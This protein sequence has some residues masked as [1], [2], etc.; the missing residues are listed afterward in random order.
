M[1]PPQVLVVPRQP[2]KVKLAVTPVSLLAVYVYLR[3]RLDDRHKLVHELVKAVQEL[4][5]FLP[6]GQTVQQRQHSPEDFHIF[7]LPIPIFSSRVLPSLLIKLL[8]F[9]QDCK[10]VEYCSSKNDVLWQ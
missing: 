4:P 6:N 3:H 1:A 2:F 7:R 8:S 10:V 5:A 9:S